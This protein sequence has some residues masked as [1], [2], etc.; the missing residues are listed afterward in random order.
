[1]KLPCIENKCLLY[2]VC[3]SKVIVKCTLL[4]KYVVK[5][6]NNIADVDLK[7]HVEWW[8]NNIRPFLINIE[9]VSNDNNTL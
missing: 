2:P 7:G 1:M 5:G 4:H 9:C 3:K 6:R 8:H